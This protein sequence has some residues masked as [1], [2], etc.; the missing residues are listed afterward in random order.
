DV[1][2]AWAAGGVV[3][4][5]AA[6]DEGHGEEAEVAAARE[7]RGAPEDVHDA[8]GPALHR[9]GRAE[10]GR[11]DVQE[12]RVACEA[13]D[14]AVIAGGGDDADVDLDAVLVEDGVGVGECPRFMEKP[15]AR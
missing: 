11:R 14:A 10:G 7:G 13:G 2:H 12:E 8:D 9:A 1:S 3:L 6:P 5:E 15:G 4:R